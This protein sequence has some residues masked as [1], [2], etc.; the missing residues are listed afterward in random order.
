VR[1]VAHLSDLH[2]GTEDP[3]VVA[4]LEADLAAVRPSLVVVSGDLTQRA[5]PREFRAARAFLDALPAPW[6]AVPGN[7]DIPL[8][9]VARRF[10]SP[11]GRWRSLLG[12]DPDPVFE[13]EELLVIGISTARSNVWKGGRI[14]REQLTR[15]RALLRMAHGRLTALVAHH[16]FAPPSGLPRAPLVG[17]VASAV[18]LLDGEGLD[19]VLT[20]HL[21]QGHTG[22]LREHFA[23]LGRSILTAH[24]S[25]SVSRRRRGDEPNAYNLLELG[26]ARVELE[27]RA[28]S[29]Q[30]FA[31]A[32]RVA[33]ARGPDGWAR[34]PAAPD[35]P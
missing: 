30:A 8:F 20:G 34:A 31:P 13:D 22:D 25:T 18:A 7:H 24:A 3:P 4:A 33:F 28:F 15:L 27:A 35:G 6:L 19:L 29:G 17:R 32:G 5:R 10:L 16:P 23:A 2:F 1:T 9:D 21:H 26:R 12:A 14:S 11:L